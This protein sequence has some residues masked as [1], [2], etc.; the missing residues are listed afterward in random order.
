MRQELIELVKELKRLDI[1]AENYI[2][3]LPSEFSI[4][5]DNDYTNCKGL[6]FDKTAQI[7]FGSM[8]EDIMWFLYEWKP[9]NKKPQI[10]LADGTTYV[11]ETEED[12]YKY[13]ETK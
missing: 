7:L 4:I 8:Y 9:G 5:F 3:K 1:Q 2:S 10:W 11:L 12:Y 13:L 6:M